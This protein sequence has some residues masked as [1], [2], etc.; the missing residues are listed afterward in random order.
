MSVSIKLK[1]RPSHVDGRE[2]SLYFQ[3]VS[4][5]KAHQHTTSYRIMS[6]DWDERKQSIIIP[7][8]SDSRYEMIRTV[9]R[10]V[11]WELSALSRLTNRMIEDDE[12]TDVDDVIETW[13]EYVSQQPFFAYMQSVIDRLEKE[14][15]TGTSEKYRSAMRSFERFHGSQNLMLYEVKPEH[16]EDYQHWLTDNGVS[17]NTISFYM[18]I[19]RAVFNR[20][21]KQKLIEHN[22]LFQSVYTGIGET[23]KRAIELSCI[24]RIKD[25]DL[26]EHTNLE[27]ARDLFLFSFYCR[28]MAFV[29]MAYLKKTD[30]ANGYLTYNRH[31][32]KQ[33]LIIKWEPQMQKIVEKYQ[34]DTPFLLP[35]IKNN[36]ESEYSQYKRMNKNVCRWLKIVGKKANIN[37][38]LTIYVARHSWS[39]IAK[40]RN[41]SISTISKALGH[42]SEKTT[43]IY[44]ASL[45]NSVV[46]DANNDILSELR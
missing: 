32:T 14:C 45:D 39:S 15:R 10:R 9:R 4:Q 43:Q 41:H 46:D 30:A 36:E 8:K 26:H 28:G 22:H 23:P 44:L 7:P 18:R 20:A 38:E 21:A 40:Q 5:R 11:R 12:N 42:T 37:S 1:F 6:S 13:R 16:I 27:L 35:I 31:K 29:D 19:L 17:M 2:G 33:Q 3:F 24:Q 34:T 25:L